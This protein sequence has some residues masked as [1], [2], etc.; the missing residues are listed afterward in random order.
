M[1]RSRASLAHAASRSRRDMLCLK[2]RRC[3][4]TQPRAYYG[5]YAVGVH[6]QSNPNMLSR[7]DLFPSEHNSNQATAF[8]KPGHQRW[9]QASTR[10]SERHGQAAPVFWSSHQRHYLRP[11]GSWGLRRASARRPQARNRERSQVSIHSA[12][13]RGNRASQTEGAPCVSYHHYEAERA[14]RRLRSE[15]RSDSSSL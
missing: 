9:K 10:I 4:M 11:L 12:L 6:S 5:S 3:G 8:F 14:I 13:N 2:R 15:A 1:A 7:A